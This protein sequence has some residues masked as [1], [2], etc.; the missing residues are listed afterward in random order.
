MNTFEALF[1]Y[2]NRIIAEY[3]RYWV[4]QY[5]RMQHILIAERYENPSVDIRGGD[6]VDKSYEEINR[7]LAEV[8]SA[9][10]AGRYRIDRNRKRRANL[11]LY[12]D[13]VIGEEMTREILL[14]LTADD[15]CEVAPNE[16]EE[17][18][19]EQLYVFGKDVKLLQRF[20]VKEET[21]SLYIKLNK[22]ENQYVIIISFHKQAYP[23][24]YAFQ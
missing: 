2:D 16:H 8:K 11:K 4:R 20:G 1:D 22:Q 21:V 9:V 18:K 10:W 6:L 24:T 17:Y 13:Y 3:R 19:H 7:Y 14:S 15:F 23:L 12:R 5:F